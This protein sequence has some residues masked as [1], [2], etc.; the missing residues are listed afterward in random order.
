MFIFTI[1]QVSSDNDSNPAN[2]ERKLMRNITSG[3]QDVSDAMHFD[4]MEPNVLDAEKEKESIDEKPPSPAS[5]DLKSAPLSADEKVKKNTSGK[6]RHTRFRVWYLLAVADIII[7]SI[8]IGKSPSTFY[9][10][11][12]VNIC[13]MLFQRVLV[14]YRRRMLL[15]LLSLCYFCSA[16]AI[17]HLCYGLSSIKLAKLTFAIGMGPMLGTSVLVGNALILHSWNHISLIYI[18]W[19]LGLLAFTLR[20]Y[21]PQA[22]AFSAAASPVEWDAISFQDFV[23]N[24]TYFYIAWVVFYFTFQFVVFRGLIAKYG[25]ESQYSKTISGGMGLISKVTNLAPPRWRAVSFAIA[26]YLFFIGPIFYTLLLWKSFYG[27]VFW[28]SWTLTL[29]AWRGS[30]RQ[31]VLHEKSN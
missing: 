27:S 16:G 18:H 17:L 14:F 3:F 15:F 4:S 11:W 1:W 8:W 22:L 12:I 9:K 7:S 10:F 6:A 26:C 5:T 31:V 20:W 30:K 21:P 25:Y 13:G 24:P 23:L 28:L 19:G 29:I 2:F